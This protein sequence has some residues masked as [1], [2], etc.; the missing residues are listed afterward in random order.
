MKAFAR[1]LADLHHIASA[2]SIQ[3]FPAEAMRLLRKWIAF[4]GAVLGMGR[5]EPVPQAT[6]EIAEAYVHNRA[7][8][9]LDDYAEVS[10]ADPITHAFLDGL[11]AP[12]RCD[13][14]SLYASRALDALATFSRRHDLHHLMIF[15]DAPLAQAPA[16]WLVM[17]RGTA[18]PFSAGDEQR[19]YALWLHLDIAISANWHHA[20]ER[21]A[22]DRTAAAN[23][24]A[25]S[26]TAVTGA[27]RRALALATKHG[28][29]LAADPLFVA[30]MRREW[31]DFQEISLPQPVLDSFLQRQGYRGKC[32]DI[33]FAGYAGCIACSVKPVAPARLSPAENRVAML[34]SAGMSQKEVARA[35]GVSEH[36]VRAQLK[37]AY[38]KLGVHD[39]AELTRYVVLNS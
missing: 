14:R 3:E 33:Q 1:A 23:S 12:L 24:P 19:L 8:C 34:F 30:L 18:L 5:A 25:D 9:I 16:R 10:A 2:A 17:Y 36:T 15:G 38:A 37:S 22:S 13:C 4:D 35:L 28:A 27:M 32:I 11:V 29:I 6:L 39:K 31:P 21:I 7:P 26:A 20:L